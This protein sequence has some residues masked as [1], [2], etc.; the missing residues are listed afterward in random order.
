MGALPIVLATG[1]IVALV[2]TAKKSKAGVNLAPI[3]VTNIPGALPPIGPP[4]VF[5]GASGVQWLIHEVKRAN[6]IVTMDV[7]LNDPN[8]PAKPHMVIRFSAP[9]SNPE[10]RTLVEKGPSTPQMIQS[11]MSDLKVPG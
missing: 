9:L 2:V 5:R 8:I 6:G 3:N 4:S 10:T 7:I 11:A 1:A